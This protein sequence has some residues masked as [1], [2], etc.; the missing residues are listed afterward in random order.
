MNG[1][2]PM[3]GK[4]LF[5][6]PARIHI[7]KPDGLIVPVPPADLDPTELKNF[8]SPVLALD[9]TGEVSSEEVA[10]KLKQSM[11]NLENEN[12]LN[13]QELT[14]LMFENSALKETNTRFQAQFVQLVERKPSSGST[15]PKSSQNPPPT[16]WRQLARYTGTGRQ[17]TTPFTISGS[18]WRLRWS[19]TPQDN[20]GGFLSV[21][22]QGNQRTLLVNTVEPGNNIS[23][24]SGKGRFSLEI[25]SVGM[26][27]TLVVEEA[28]P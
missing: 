14:R 24:V 19:C 11:E 9:P 3:R 26:G 22:A 8:P 5:Y 20:F 13:R 25:A 10:L 4:L 21:S 1:K 15:K 17:H 12:R 18:E 7:E 6:A 28:V 23:Y 16:I 27:W 2:P